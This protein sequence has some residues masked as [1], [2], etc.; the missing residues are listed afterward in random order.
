MVIRSS[1]VN[2]DSSFAFA[3][4]DAAVLKFILL[5]VRRSPGETNDATTRS[6]GKSATPFARSFEHDLRFKV[7]QTAAMPQ[8]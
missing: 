4:I 5:I 8:F 3:P 6:R 2:F 1:A 7:F